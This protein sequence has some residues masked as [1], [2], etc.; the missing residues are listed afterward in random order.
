MANLTPLVRIV[1]DDPTIC[2]SQSFFLQ[3][4]GW[5]T[6]TYQDPVTFLERD[7]WDRPGCI[8]LDVR[9]P[10]LSGLEVQQELNKRGV[11]LPIIFLSAHG[12]IEMAMNCVEQGAFNFLV[13]P[14]IPEKLKDLV[15][16][17]I[18]L[19]KSQRKIKKETEELQKLFS[20]LTSTEQMV[21][22]QVAKGL[23]NKMIGEVLDMSERT[24]QSHRSKVFAK[25]DVGNAVELF[26]FLSD[27][28]NSSNL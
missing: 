6:V 20:Q 8:I 19:N 2:D 15:E 28:D 21:A 16:K 17:A 18:K 27:M 4:A 12:D 7:D 25:L 24:V 11:D 9:M 23:T 1:D 5:Q 14:P 22:R 13:K 3:L 26:Q 10:S